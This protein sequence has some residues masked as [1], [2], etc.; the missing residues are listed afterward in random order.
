V[1]CARCEQTRSLELG[2]W[3]TPP[4]RASLDHLDKSRDDPRGERRAAEL[5]QKLLALGLSRFEPNL[6]L[7]I[8]E[9]QQRQPAK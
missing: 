1:F 2:P 5:L 3:Q 4:S 6:L 7:A 8:A 9:A